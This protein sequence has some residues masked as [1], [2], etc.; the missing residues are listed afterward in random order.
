MS[1]D[2]LCWINGSIIPAHEAQI[3]VFDHGLLY[4]D[5]VFEGIRF[6]NGRSFRLQEHLVRLEKSARAIALTLP[7]SLQEMAAFIEATVNAATFSDGYLRVV[8]TRGAGSLGLDPRACPK[9]T[10]FIIADRLQ[11]VTPE[12]CQK[13]AR[14][15][16]ASTRRLPVDGL[17]PRVKSLNYLNHILARIEANQ[18]GM[19]EA[20]LLNRNGHVAEGTADN[21]FV[22][23]DGVLLTPPVSDGALEGITRNLIIELALKNGVPLREQSLAPY[24]LHTADEVFLTG[25]GAELIPVREIDGRAM[26]QCPGQRFRQLQEL[27]T[28]QVAQ[29]T[30]PTYFPP[31]H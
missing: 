26:T 3:S 31:A 7:Y 25:T 13:G 28:A 29:E 23:R 9:P 1:T 8:I 15:I 5:G 18:A 4:G 10:F 17:D 24:D 2:A 6:Y 21:I 22:V 16:T 11:M 12:A 27:F 19:D 20:I 14:L 30:D